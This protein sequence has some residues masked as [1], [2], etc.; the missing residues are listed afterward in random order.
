MTISTPTM[1]AFIGNLG[2]LEWT[3]ILII[4]LLLFGRRL[5]EVGKSFGQGI[6]EFKKGLKDVEEDVKRDDSTTAR[7]NA[8]PGDQVMP[9]PEGT[10]ERSQQR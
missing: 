6:R 7:R 10:Q 8:L 1:L 2:P 3:V 4:A 5:P 9:S